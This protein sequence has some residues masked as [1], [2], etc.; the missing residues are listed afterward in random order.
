MVEANQQ[1]S[2]SSTFSPA[3]K[4]IDANGGN[5]PAAVKSLTANALS[6][7]QV[8][9]GWS[10]PAQQAN[11]P[12]AFEIYRGVSSGNYSYVGQVDPSIDSY[13]DSNLSPKTKYFYA[14]RAI[15][16]TGA[17][18][19]SNEASTTTSSDTTAPSNPGNL[20]TAYTTPSTITIAWDASTDNVG[21]DRYN[22]Y[23]NGS[24]SNVT[25]Q[26]SFVLTGLVQSQPY[27]IYVTAVDGSNNTSGASNQITA[28]PILGGLKYS[29]YTTNNAWS[30]L[31]AFSTLT[32]VAQGV[33]SNTDISVATQS[34]NYGFLWQGYIQVPVNGTYTFGTTSDDGSA[35][36][37]N[38]YTPTG[39][40]TVNNDGAHASQTKTGSSITLTAGIYPICIE[41]FQ[42]G[43]GANMSVSWACTALFGNSS[44]HNIDNKYF[45][46]TY[47]NSGSVPAV[48]T[49][50]TATAL[51]YN[52]IKVNWAD[53]SNNET[54]F[55]V[56]RA[57]SANGNYQIA[58][59][60]A[61]NTTSF[62][63]SALAASTTYY[64]KVQAINKYGNSGLSTQDTTASSTNGLNYYFYTGTWS[65]LP[66]FTTLTPSKTGYSSTTDLSVATQSTNY[67]FVWH[68]Y[69]KITK[70]G[71]YT[72]QT[73]SDDGSALWINSNTAS[74]TP[75][76]NND[77]L[78][79]S[80]TKTSSSISL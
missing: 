46:G 64:Y 33:S 58:G 3:Y 28:E 44:Q 8:Q 14:I 12:T 68:G 74:G 47:V 41:F 54:G 57:T 22:I 59:T 50:V 70:S 2:C 18:A 49:T 73:T 79:G 15:D 23:V 35:L 25:K 6:N 36:W 55:E 10:S 42:A 39:T 77:G 69:L 37:F 1:Y 75:T 71:S 63:D 76:V 29:Y 34:S 45:V 24:L 30:V 65:V 72:F 66:D 17:A 40:P 60:V 78:H 7:T 19:L 11:P 53:K 51:T 38:S 48:P 9:L 13:T 26:T 80:T 32:P 21:V 20:R 16:S 5:A 31:P 67:G 56:Y 62:T 4:V 27:A 61:A 52:K 43:G